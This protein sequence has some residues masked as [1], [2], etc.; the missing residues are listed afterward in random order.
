LIG[1]FDLELYKKLIEQKE[2]RLLFTIAYFRDNER[3]S[4]K[5]NIFLFQELSEKPE[6][7]CGI[8]EE[9]CQ[10]EK[11]YPRGN[12]ITMNGYSLMNKLFSIEGFKVNDEQKEEFSKLFNKM[13]NAEFKAKYPQFLP[14][15]AIGTREGYARGESEDFVSVITE[16]GVAPGLGSIL[17]F[18]H[19]SL[20]RPLAVTHARSSP[21]FGVG[22]GAAAGSSSGGGSG[23]VSNNLTGHN[24]SSDGR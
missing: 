1:S 21:E 7:V 22:A 16:A 19:T 14:S 17:R 5:A 8:M 2:Y 4:G 11:I 23:V 9:I 12:S 6:V 20:S 3:L 10:E 24:N 15:I 13:G 18:P